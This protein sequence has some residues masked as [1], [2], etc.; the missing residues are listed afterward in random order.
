M[1]LLCKLRQLTEHNK[2]PGKCEDVVEGTE[3]DKDINTSVK[4]HS[5]QT[6]SDKDTDTSFKSQFLRLGAKPKEP[7]LITEENTPKEKDAVR[8]RKESSRLLRLRKTKLHKTAKASAA[9]QASRVRHSPDKPIKLTAIPFMADHALPVEASGR[10]SSTAHQT[11]TCDKE[12][13][14]CCSH[15]SKQGQSGNNQAAEKDFMHQSESDNVSSHGFRSLPSRLET[16]N[17]QNDLSRRTC[18]ETDIASE[19]SSLTGWEVDKSRRESVNANKMHDAMESS[20]GESSP[21]QSE[22]SRD[23]R[24]QDKHGPLTRQ[25]TDSE[26]ESDTEYVSDSENELSDH[27]NQ[28]GLSQELQEVLAEFRGA[29]EIKT[30]KH[31]LT[32]YNNV[33]VGSEAVRALIEKQIVESE[34]DALEL[35]NELLDAGVFHHVEREHNFQNAYVF[36]RFSSHRMPAEGEDTSRTHKTVFGKLKSKV[37]HS[38][39]YLQ[40]KSKLGAKK[41]VIQNLLQREV[42]G[43]TMKRELDRKRT[44]TRNNVQQ[45]GWFHLSLL[46]SRFVRGKFKIKVLFEGQ[47]ARL[48]HS[49]QQKAKRGRR[50]SQVSEDY[51]DLPDTDVDSESEMESGAGV[52]N[53]QG[54]GSDLEEGGYGMD[55]DG[56]PKTGS[57]AKRPEVRFPVTD[58][59][60][61]VIL[62]I[63][64]RKVRDKLLGQII[65]PLVRFLPPTLASFA[66][67]PPGGLKLPAQMLWH[68]IFPLALERNKFPQGIPGLRHSA[69]DRP[70]ASLGFLQLRSELTLTRRAVSS[71]CCS[72]RFV[73]PQHRLVDVAVLKLAVLRIQRALG[74]HIKGAVD[75][76][77]WGIVNLLVRIALWESRTQSLGF[78][79]VWGYSCFFAAIHLYPLIAAAALIFYSFDSKGKKLYRLVPWNDEV[80]QNP[81]DARTALGKGRRLQLT[82]ALMQDRLTTLASTLEK[83]GNLLNWTDGRI[84]FIFLV[85]VSVAAVVLSLCLY[86]FATLNRLFFSVVGSWLGHPSN[87]SVFWFC[88]GTA[89]LAWGLLSTTRVVR[90]LRT[91]VA[92]PLS[93]SRSLV[94]NTKHETE[95]DTSAQAKELGEQEQAKAKWKV[96]NKQET[97]KGSPVPER[98]SSVAAISISPRK[99]KRAADLSW[100]DVLC[101]DDTSQNQDDSEGRGRQAVAATGGVDCVAGQ[102][103]G[104]ADDGSTHFPR[105]TDDGQ[106]DI[107]ARTSQKA[108]HE[109]ERRAESNVQQTQQPGGHRQE[110]AHVTDGTENS[111]LGVDM[112]VVNGTVGDADQRVKE[113]I[114]PPNLSNL[115]NPSL[116][117]VRRPVEVTTHAAIASRAVEDTASKITTNP[118]PKAPAAFQSPPSGPS[119]ARRQPLRRSNAKAQLLPIEP[120]PPQVLS[121]PELDDRLHLSDPLLLPT[122]SHSLPQLPSQPRGSTANHPP[123]LPTSRTESH[124]ADLHSQRPNAF[125]E[126]LTRKQVRQEVSDE[127][128]RK[129]KDGAEEERRKKEKK[130]QER[131]LEKEVT[132]Q[133]KKQKKLNEEIEKMHK[134][135]KDKQ[136]KQH[137]KEVDRVRKTTLKF[138]HPEGDS[139]PVPRPASASTPVTT[140]VL[141]TSDHPASPSSAPAV[142][143]VSAPSPATT[144]ARQKKR[145]K[146]GWRWRVRETVTGGDGESLPGWLVRTAG[147]W[148]TNLMARIPDDQTVCHRMIAELQVSQADP[149]TLQHS[150]VLCSAISLASASSSSSSAAAAANTEALSRASLSVATAN[151]FA[152]TSAPNSPPA[153][154]VVRDHSLSDEDTASDKGK[155]RWAKSS[156]QAKATGRSRGNGGR[157]WSLAAGLRAHRRP[158]DTGEG[159]ASMLFFA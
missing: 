32:K 63:Y 98:P 131:D 3:W 78:V 19:N 130:V 83:A 41:E 99:G 79:C 81:D 73:E 157:R 143:T 16:D 14:S 46:D 118:I 60:A 122:N 128:R 93:P 113:F 91:S 140:P 138:S 148:V 153:A 119:A 127:K 86:M 34:E 97:D 37:T 151:L 94:P 137:K 11:G 112:S 92:Q 142:I 70:S 6:D 8:V 156:S 150:A 54:E 101:P 40:M 75:A 100:L 76:K 4:P 96:Q 53:G 155:W 111:D 133:K 50:K 121:P 106:G 30:L 1:S 147:D 109:D 66:S 144:R 47:E 31:R 72:P 49:R 120:P 24:R 107:S 21:N 114:T 65:I 132:K 154:I 88:L 15:S 2:K 69:M 68:E 13:D 36:Y 45:I 18:L 27:D 52:G 90:Q 149:P 61:D 42:Y 62:Q 124:I 67:T 129:K 58:I 55:S 56:V 74:L 84:T 20:E 103:Q 28:E 71:Y 80:W 116:S 87:S 9:E 108:G 12:H 17:D 33:F 145:L 139:P 23:F 57:H 89:P 123:F 136:L 95:R 10:E 126:L 7:H 39:R 146:K 141:Q 29:V 110:D 48:Q 64:Q 104:A 117:S 38:K 125:Q 135:K 85:G 22:Y 152:S 82:L 59:T 102:H 158:A 51:L 159:L 25:M 43:G 5:L 44:Q 105:N 115:Q 134:K 26:F 77:P 35:G